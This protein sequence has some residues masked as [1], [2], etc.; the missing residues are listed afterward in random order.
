MVRTIAQAL[1]LVFKRIQ[2]TPD[3]MPFRHHGTTSSRRIQ[4]RTP[5]VDFS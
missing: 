5:H 2:F 3:L 4:P 1:G